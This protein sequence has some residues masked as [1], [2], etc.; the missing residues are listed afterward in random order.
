M[1][2]ELGGRYNTEGKRG[3]VNQSSRKQ[4]WYESSKASEKVF[5]KNIS[6]KISTFSNRQNSIWLEILAGATV[7]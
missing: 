3:K 6:A 7:H 2:K 1:G 5:H 4:E